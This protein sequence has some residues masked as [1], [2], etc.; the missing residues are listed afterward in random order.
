VLSLARAFRPSRCSLA[1]AVCLLA[2]SASAQLQPTTTPNPVGSGARALGMGAA[3]VA[4]A[5]DATAASWNPG[6][7]TQLQRPEVSAVYNFTWNNEDFQS[8]TRPGFNREHELPFNSLNYASVAYPFPFTLK[9]RNIVVSLNF[10]RKYDF[11]RDLNVDFRTVGAVGGTVAN[12]LTD[13]DYVQR[14][15]LSAL[16]PAIAMELTNKLS[17][18]VAWNIFNENIIPQ[19]EW[20]NRRIFR[21]RIA[22]IR[23]PG[24]DNQINDEYR[25]FT[26]NNFTLGLLWKPTERLSFGVVYN[27]K[28]TADVR[29]KRTQKLL[30]S[31]GDIVTA[32]RAQRYTFPSSFAVGVAYRFP[33]DKLTLSMDST[34]REWDQF[35]IEDPGNP[36]PGFQRTSGVTGIDV[37]LSEVDPTYTVRIGGEYVFVD[38]TS[39]KQNVLPS[40]RAGVF[41]DPEPSGGRDSTFFG[42]EQRGDG[43]VDDFFGFS[44]GAGVLIKDRVNIDAAYVYR[45]GNAAR[46][47]TFQ[48]NHVDADVKQ[49]NLFFSTVIYF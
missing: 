14:G 49:H 25:D 41:Y 37:D 15:G 4:V 3:F 12:V 38:D 23:V 29:F 7:L 19:N 28:M 9:G 2:A 11:D 17:I 44:I 34:R 6:G 8:A 30:G 26:G 22:G 42:L 10:Q 24:M 18:G 47:D 39:P 45:F 40:V 20:E 31:F 1:A 13:V 48:L 16:S 35:V 43:R 5:D 21:S 27:T 33:N 36:L 46:V 32:D